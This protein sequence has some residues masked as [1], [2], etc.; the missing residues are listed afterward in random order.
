MS[1]YNT[2]IN[3]TPVPGTG[4]TAKTDSFEEWRKKRDAKEAA[5]GWS[6]TRLKQSA[7]LIAHKRK[8][9][10]DLLK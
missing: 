9:L 5:A 10:K 4:H 3:D 7:R 8:E 6:R 1:Y 2:D